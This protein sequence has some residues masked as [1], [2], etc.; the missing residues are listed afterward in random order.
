MVL[1][2]SKI[3]ASPTKN[4][5]YFLLRIIARLEKSSQSLSI[6]YFKKIYVFIGILIHSRTQ[7]QA[8]HALGMVVL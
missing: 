8:N 5:N 6:W 4:G 7:V 3:V 2:K 1:Y